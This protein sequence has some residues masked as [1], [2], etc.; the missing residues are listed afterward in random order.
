MQIRNN[1]DKDVYNGDMGR[2]SDLDP[3]EQ[4]LVV[5]FNSTSGPVQIEYEKGDIDQLVLAYA[6]SV[7]KAQGSEFPAV[8]MPLVTQHHVL[9]QRNLLYTAITRAR[10]LCVLVGSPKALAVAV[11]A[12]HRQRRNTALGQRL[13]LPLADDVLQL[14]LE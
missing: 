6:I 14:T 8:V 1:Y 11:A 12:D 2:V 9:L 4:R 7:H 3:V 10:R 13:Q 5:A